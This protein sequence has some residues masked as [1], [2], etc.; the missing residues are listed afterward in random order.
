MSVC[1]KC[2]LTTQVPNSSLVIRLMACPVLPPG[3]ANSASQSPT[4]KSSWRYSAVEQGGGGGGG[5][6]G[7]AAA[8]ASAMSMAGLRFVTCCNRPLRGDKGGPTRPAQAEE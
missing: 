3:S 8:T 4:Q 6:A 2:S 7:A 5:V 1:R